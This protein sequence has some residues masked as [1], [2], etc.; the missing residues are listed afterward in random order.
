[1]SSSKDA[2]GTG[3]KKET[4]VRELRALL[5]VPVAF[6]LRDLRKS[7]LSRMES[8]SYLYKLGPLHSLLLDPLP[9]SGSAETREL[10]IIQLYLWGFHATANFGR[11]PLALR[12]SVSWQQLEQLVPHVISGLWNLDV[13]YKSFQQRKKEPGLE[14]EDAIQLAQM[15]MQRGSSSLPT[16]SSSGQA[17]QSTI[18]TVPLHWGPPYVPMQPRLRHTS[19][20][21]LGGE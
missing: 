19:A 20:A 11:L 4:H 3:K 21:T 15:M 10:F 13:A 17:A 5:G 16:P 8:H 14:M 6:R 18:L 7:I 1:M 2:Q 12:R 9:T